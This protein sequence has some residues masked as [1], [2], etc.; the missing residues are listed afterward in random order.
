MFGKW[1]TLSHTIAFSYTRNL[2]MLKTSTT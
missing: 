1:P 2:K